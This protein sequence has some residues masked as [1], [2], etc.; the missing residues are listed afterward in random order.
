MLKFIAV[1]G[2]ICLSTNQCYAD[3]TDTDKSAWRVHGCLEEI[4]KN[5]GVAGIDWDLEKKR[6]RNQIKLA[7]VA[8]AEYAAMKNSSKKLI[9]EMSEFV[10]LIESCVDGDEAAQKKALAKHGLSYGDPVGLAEFT[11]Q[12]LKSIA[13]KIK[14][15]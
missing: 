11:E 3:K 15:R 4:V 7:R 6:V 14:A 1:A 13:N 9:D 2:L 8:I 12:R 5:C 10:D